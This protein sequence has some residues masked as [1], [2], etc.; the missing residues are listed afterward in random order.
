MGAKC[1]KAEKEKRIIEVQKWIIDGMS[2]KE[3]ISEIKSKWELGLRMAR[4]YIKLAY[5]SFMPQEHIN[6]ENRRAAKIVELK[7][8]LRDMK[9]KFKGTPQ[10]MNARARIHKM[11][12]KLEDIEP[13]KRHE[14]NGNLNHTHQHE[15][16]NIDPLED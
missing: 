1:T 16:L 15:V 11:I 8:E 14:V 3:V 12:I 9:A 2:D 6:I 7:Q 10:G 13:A 4:K 5:D